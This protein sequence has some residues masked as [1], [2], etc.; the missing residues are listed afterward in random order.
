MYTYLYKKRCLC[1]FCYTGK[2]TINVGKPLEHS[3]S[4]VTSVNFARKYLFRLLLLLL[5]GLLIDKMKSFTKSYRR[6]W[7]FHIYL[8]YK[9]IIRHDNPHGEK[10]QND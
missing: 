10:V 3:F 2:I 4:V 6:L 7:P 1:M 8:P 5:S 9:V